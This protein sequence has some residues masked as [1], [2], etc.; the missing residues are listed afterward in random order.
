MFLQDL[1][2][3]P[4][5]DRWLGY[6]KELVD[7]FRMLGHYIR[8]SPGVQ[9]ESHLA[10]LPDGHPSVRLILST[11]QVNQGLIGLRSPCIHC[12]LEG[13]SPD[14]GGLDG[15]VVGFLLVCVDGNKS[16]PWYQ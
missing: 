5:T 14:Q 13:S 7:G 12:L 3:N 9:A 16:M 2:S 15:V 8:L 11:L 1:S 4:V 6:F 10:R